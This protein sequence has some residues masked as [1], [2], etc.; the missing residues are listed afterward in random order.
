[1]GRIN[2]RHAPKRN[3][4]DAAFSAVAESRRSPGRDSI[5]IPA[6]AETFTQTGCG[7]RLTDHKGWFVVETSRHHKYRGRIFVSAV[8]AAALIK[9]AIF[10]GTGTRYKPPK[11][12]AGL[13]PAL[14]HER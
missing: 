6:S 8:D 2:A 10:G 3:A 14:F 5:L 7:I 9:D 11:G 12:S 4:V 13:E 1:M